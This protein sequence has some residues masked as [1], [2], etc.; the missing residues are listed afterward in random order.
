MSKHLKCYHAESEI[1]QQQHKKAVGLI[2]Q[3]SEFYRCKYEISIWLKKFEKSYTHACTFTLTQAA[4]ETRLTPAH[5]WKYFK[6]FSKYLNRTIYRH[7]AKRHNKTLLIVPVLHGVTGRT[8]LHIHAAIG[9]VDRDIPFYLLKAAI[10]KA[11]RKMSWS[12]HD[13]QI[14]PFRDSG[15]IDYMLKELTPNTIH[16][17]VDLTCCCI[18]TT[19]IPETLS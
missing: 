9:C 14:I 10:N 17:C 8:H 2:S 13:T 1:T 7:A 11:W 3:R 18:P 15:W 19:L 5:A 16:Q 6:N 12:T 4:G